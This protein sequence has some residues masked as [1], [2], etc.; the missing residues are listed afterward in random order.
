MNIRDKLIKDFENIIA[1]I[2]EQIN[3]QEQIKNLKIVIETLKTKISSI[4]I[5]QEKGEKVPKDMKIKPDDITAL[6][7]DIIKSIFQI[8]RKSILLI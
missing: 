8:S 1:N 3:S 7:I 4:R 2:E 5:F 6:D